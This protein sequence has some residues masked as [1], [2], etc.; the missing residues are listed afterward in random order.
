M[1]LSRFG[2]GHTYRPWESTVN[3]IRV[4]MNG[5]TPAGTM[6]DVCAMEALTHAIRASAEARASRSVIRNG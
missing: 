2:C 6:C 1:T 4:H 3:D 5:G